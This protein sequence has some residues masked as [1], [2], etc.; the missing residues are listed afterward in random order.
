MRYR[1][2]TLDVFT[3]RVFGGNPLAVFTDGRGLSDAQMQRAARELNLSETVFV[4]PPRTPGGTRR[5]RIFAPGTELPFAGHPTVGTAYL[6]ASLGEVAADGDTADLVLEELAGPVRVRIAF[7]DG[8]PASA[9]LTAPRLPEFGSAVPDPETLAALL[10]LNVEDVPADGFGAEAVSAGVPFLI[11]PLRGAD[12][13]RRARLNP[14]V[15][16][17]HVAE[18]WAPHV[19]PFA[20]ADPEDGTDFRVRMFAPA[21]GIPEDPATGAAASAFAGYLA[22]RAEADGEMR[23]TLAQGMELG[24]PSRLEIYAVRE[25]GNITEV[26]VGGPAVRVGEGWLEIPD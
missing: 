4:Y 25:G 21:M 18:S 23:W 2:H 19:Y 15:W 16:E 9:R 7:V 6:L 5:L 26:G 22:R 17:R 8:R 12:A 24:R 10:S 3:D 20:P 13:L 14:A 11:I 1:Y